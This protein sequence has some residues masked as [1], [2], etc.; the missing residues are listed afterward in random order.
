MKSNTNPEMTKGAHVMT[1]RADCNS[2]IGSMGFA[3][4]RLLTFLTCKQQLGGTRAYV[5]SLDTTCHQ[6]MRNEIAVILR[7]ITLTLADSRGF[8]VRAACGWMAY[9]VGSPKCLLRLV[10]PYG[11]PGR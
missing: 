5:A 7:K 3:S 2:C 10:L 8:G 4:T 6:R 11:E 1:L 9:G